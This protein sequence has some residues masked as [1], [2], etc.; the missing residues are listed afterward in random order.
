MF[1]FSSFFV[2]FMLRRPPRSTRTDTT[3][4]LHDALPIYD[5]V[6][7]VTDTPMEPRGFNQRSID[8]THVDSGYSYGATGGVRY[9][10]DAFEAN[11]NFDYRS[12]EHTS[13]LQ[14]LMRHSYAVFCVKKKPEHQYQIPHY[15]TSLQYITNT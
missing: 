8:R 13:E 6:I 7:N 2:F 12:E 4:A 9:L 5:I 14:S 10:A 11:V 3:L 15:S 1:V